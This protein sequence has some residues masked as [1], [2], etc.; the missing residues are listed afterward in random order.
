MPNTALPTG[1]LKPGPYSAVPFWAVH[2]ACLLVFVTDFSWGAVAICIAVFFL[3]MFGITA[4]Y[5]RYFSHRSFKTGRV[6][7]F[8]LAFLGTMSL[9]K[10]VLWWAANHRIHHKYSDL[11]GDV[12]SPVRSGFWWSH[13]GWIL[14]PDHEETHYEKIPDLA[15]YP[16]LRW[17]NEHFLIPPLILAAA[18]Y[19]AGGL[20][21]LTWGFFLSTT[22]L[23]H[24]TF[25]I[26]SLAHVYGTRRYET[27]DTS[28]N[29]PWLAIVTMGEGW[30]NNHHS[31]MNSARQGFF[32]WEI[33]TTYYILKMLSWI[34]VTWDLIQPPA[35]LLE[36][37][38][39]APRV[40]A[41]E[42]AAG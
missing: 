40:N 20:S 10:G 38:A 1:F 2:V 41:T 26:N 18:L 15:K 17:I 12:H 29:N 9:Q 35:R 14:S 23:W 13:V 11:E 36:G 24:T 34:G 27:T 25:M 21:W 6:F 4:G 16:E 32:W 31:F 30:H 22:L 7:Q 5:H 3:R 19:A 39:V 37:E 42:S 28:R 8:V 33:D